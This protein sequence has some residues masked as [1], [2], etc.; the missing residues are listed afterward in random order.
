M[1]AYIGTPKRN[2]TITKPNIK[3]IQQNMLIDLRILIM[4]REGLGKP[5]RLKLS[6][7]RLL[8]ASNKR[9]NW[10]HLELKGLDGGINGFYLKQ[11]ESR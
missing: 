2:N 9:K 10:L 1:N 8:I 11:K 5:F 3:C 6:L 7:K 4:T